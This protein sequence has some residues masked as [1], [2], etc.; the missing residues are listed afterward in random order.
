MVR[1]SPFQGGNAGSSPVEDNY[2][3]VAM[4]NPISFSFLFTPLEQFDNVR[5]LSHEVLDTLAPLTLF[6]VEGERTP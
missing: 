3:I 2:L 4:S 1:T 6:T 5:W